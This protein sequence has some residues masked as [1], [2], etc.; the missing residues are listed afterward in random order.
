MSSAYKATQWTIVFAFLLV[1]IKGFA[2]LIS[3]SITLM[4]NFVDSGVDFLASAMNFIVVRYARK[5]ATNSFRFG[6]GKAEAL[7][8]LFQS[9]LICI[10]GAI[11]I[12]QAVFDNQHTPYTSAIL[13]LSVLIISAFITLTMIIVQKKAL[14][15]NFSLAVESDY[16]HYRTDFM[17]SITGIMAVFF[18]YQ[19]NF[20]WLDRI[21]GGIIAMY[22]IYGA[23]KIIRSSIAILMDKELDSEVRD[24]IIEIIKANPKVKDFHDLRTRSNGIKE[25]VQAHVDVDPKLDLLSAHHISEEITREI[26]KVLPNAQ[27]LIH[28]DPYG[29]E[30]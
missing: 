12:Y 9:C 27:V 19:Y 4:A 14:E 16:L 21:A 28:L 26:K 30:H 20:V 29:Y 24:Q 23:T 2:W 5:P 7:A 8:G 15:K 25:F 3:D 13:P 6:H 1:V 17:M 10:T 18:L 22:L 11:I